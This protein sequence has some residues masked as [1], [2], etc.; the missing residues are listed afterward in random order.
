MFRNAAK[1]EGSL[2]VGCTQEAPL[3]VDEAEGRAGQIEFVNLRE[4]AGWSVDG[5]QAG[6][7]MAALLAAA[8]RAHAC[9]SA[10]HLVQRRRDP[11]LRPRRDG[12]RSRQTARRPPRCHGDDYEAGSRSRRRLRH[13]SRSSREPSA[14]P[15]AIWVPSSLRSTT[16]RRHAPPRATRSSSR[17]RATALTSRCDVVL[18]LSSGPPLFP[19]HDLRDGYLRAD[20]RDPAAMLRA[21]LKARDLV[22]SFDKP[23]YIDFTADALRPFALKA[24][25]LPSL[26]RSLPDRSD[27]AG[28]RSRQ[29]QRG[30]LRRM[31][32]MRGGLSDRC[33][34]LCPAAC[35]RAAAQ[36]ARH[37]A[38]LSRSRR[39]RG[40]RAVP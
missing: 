36:I 21:V 10:R 14:T 5:P 15:R 24:D 40:D 28:R 9:L 22:G 7:K 37:A 29:D 30:N 1:A 39:F 19:A 16:M 26:S 31:R 17:L 2:I 11:D 23:K 34:L 8:C 27:H 3:F 20:P 4:T 18:D 35:R 33:S 13:L 6:P 32:P 25:G 12:G 38:S